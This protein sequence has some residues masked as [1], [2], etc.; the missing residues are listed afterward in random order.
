MHDIAQSR[1][2]YNIE[3]WSEGY[4]D[5]NE[6][7]E[8]VVSPIPNQ[9]SISLYKLAQ[10]FAANGLS[11]PV[12]VRFPNILHHRVESLCNAFAYA[13]R[14][15]NY[16]ANYTPVYP[17]KVN[18]QHHV[19]KEII[20]TGQVGLEA[21]SKAELMAVLALAPPNDGIII[22]NGYKDR[23]YIR[24]AL[25]GQQM[26]L[27]PYLVIE[28]ASEL[29]LIIAESDNLEI[30]PRL[31]I[32]VR[33]A[34]IG[35][36]KWQN[37]GGEKSKFGLNAAQVLEI[38]T[39]INEAGFID[40]FQLMHF[41]LGSQIPNIRDI[42]SGLR[43]A[44]RYYAELRA[45]GMPIQT[46]DVGGGLGID[47]DGTRSRGACSINYSIQEYANNVVHEFGDICNTLDLPQPNIIT[48][49]GRALTAHH[50]VLITNI[51]DIESAPGAVQPTPATTAEPTII[52]DL[53]YGFTNLNQ[54]SAIEAYHDAVYWLSEAQTMFTHGILNLTQRAHAEQLYYATCW[55]VRNLLQTNRHSRAYQEVLDE[56]NEKL[57]DKY[58]GNFSLFQSVPDAW[59]IKQLFPILP[60]HRLNEYPHRR[61]TLQDLTCDSD[62]QFENYVNNDGVSTSLPVHV[63][64]PAEPYLLGIFLIGAYQE[65]RRYA[66][67]VWGYL[68][69]QCAY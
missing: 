2:L 56:L 55:Q 48:E 33:L 43:E 13:M 32:R 19:V 14:I 67:F 3:N 52:Q 30:I 42:Q 1:V 46:V 11:L 10:S 45:L 60:L 7:G 53:W 27:H 59:A 21:G 50:A 35:K 18:Q 65:I 12:L 66:Q 63:P 57:A 44:A 8:M 47:Y 51:I 25:I 39:C 54:R 4:F 17:I 36:G 41:H 38:I 69:R 24:L 23:E 6:A 37:T 26:G 15:E 34:S 20:S 49:S 31:G 28:K 62:G 61:A 9:V 58:F 29:N 16:H 40:S 68:F 22:C 64:N 5:I